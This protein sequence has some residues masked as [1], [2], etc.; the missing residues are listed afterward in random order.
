M[1]THDSGSGSGRGRR[2]APRL[3]LLLVTV[4]LCLVV[5]ETVRGL[6]V[7]RGRR[8]HAEQVEPY[9]PWSL[10]AR[11]GDRLGWQEG[12]LELVL[13][14]HV[15]Y[16][17]RPGRETP[18][19][20][21]NARGFRGPEIREPC[22]KAH[23][24][25]VLGGSAAFGTGLRRDADTFAAQLEA[26]LPG[27][28]V[29]NAAVI[30]YHSGEELLTLVE[31]VIDLRPD[32]VIAFDGWNDWQFADVR[33]GVFRDQL[34]YLLR[35]ATRLTDHAWGPR[36]ALLPRILFP[37]LCNWIFGRYDLGRSAPLVPD[38]PDAVAR[39]YAANAAKMDRISR[40][41]GAR[42]LCLL[43]PDRKRKGVD[44]YGRPGA[45]YARFRETATRVLDAEGVAWLDLNGVEG[46]FVPGMFMDRVHCTAAG[47]ARLA[48]AA[49]LEIE[50]RG[51]LG[52]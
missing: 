18:Y 29:I 42:F 20:R 13:D 19:F 27:A 16:R 33:S 12:Y 4:L 46:I 23:R 11:N 45:T 17:N 41:F 50:R 39:A 38:D 51:M 1:R 44:L 28:E 52:R 14:P 25:V 31:R 22:P 9:Y 6:W 8:K 43:Q 35:F 24:V 10:R 49:A 37:A 32:L 5:L 2:P 34:E 47:Y 21:I 3:L 26:R 7:D 15:G 40:A 36:L 30:G 48:E